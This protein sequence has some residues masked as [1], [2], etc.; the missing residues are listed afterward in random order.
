MVMLTDSDFNK[1]DGN[2]R[3][4]SVKFK[5]TMEEHSNAAFREVKIGVKSIERAD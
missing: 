1:K 2:T 3:Q 4:I 5:V